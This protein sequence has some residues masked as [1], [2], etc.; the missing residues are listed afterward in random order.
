LIAFSV[1]ASNPPSD[2]VKYGFSFA[3]EVIGFLI[4]LLCTGLF[5]YGARG[6]SGYLSF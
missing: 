2:G 3:A 4:C 5:W 1:Y 6:G